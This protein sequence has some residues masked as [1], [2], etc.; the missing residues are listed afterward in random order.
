MLQVSLN[1]LV[2]YKFMYHRTSHEQSPFVT[3]T[4]AA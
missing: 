4:A 1:I 3:A 2:K